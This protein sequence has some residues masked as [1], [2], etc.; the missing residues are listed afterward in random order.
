MIYTTI[1]NTLS[2]IGLDYLVSRI[3]IVHRNTTIINKIDRLHW[4]LIAHQEFS[5]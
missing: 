5:I 1:N 4:A 2:M 3:N